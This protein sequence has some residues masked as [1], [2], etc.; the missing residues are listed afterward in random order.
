MDDPVPVSGEVGA[1]AAGVLRNLAAARRS[2][3][4]GVGDAGGIEGGHRT[5][6]RDG[7]LVEAGKALI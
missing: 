7:L 6:L 5:V 4:L 1:G 2:G 3:T